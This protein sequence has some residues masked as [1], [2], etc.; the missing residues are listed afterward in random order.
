[1]EPAQDL[2]F[3]PG[4]VEEA[5][6]DLVAGFS[7]AAL[8]LPQNMAY[9]LIAG[10]EPIYGLYASIVAMVVGA[11][12]GP[13]RYLIVGPTNMMAM[14]IY[15]SLAGVEG[16]YFQAVLLFTLMIGVFQILM[17]ILR[18]GELVNYISRSVIN[19]LTAGV[20][21]LIVSGQLGSLTGIEH[22]SGFNIVMELYYFFI[23]LE[24]LNI[25]AFL[26]GIL[27]IAVILSKKFLPITFPGYLISMI[28]A[29]AITVVLGWHQHVEVVEYFP[30]GLPSF[31]PGPINFE[32]M[33]NYAP[34]ALSVALLGFI[35]VLGAL[36]SMEIHTGEELD[37]NRVF[38]SQGIINIVCSFFSG[39]AVTGS[40]IKVLPICRQVL[41]AVFPS[42]LPL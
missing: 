30:G 12:L 28:I 4:S 33:V 13:S 34:A 1:M 32:F 31:T 27:T 11:I 24:H 37:F 17:V 6:D 15:S 5:R 14:A 21:L 10:L 22:E 42:C 18:L 35:H 7:V 36:K 8:A 3:M 25:Y 26:I 39:F 38:F 9:A 20:A 23:S 41:K 2:S 19:G 40:L 16:N 29:V